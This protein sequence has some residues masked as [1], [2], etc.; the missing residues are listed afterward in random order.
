MKSCFLMG[1]SM[2]SLSAKWAE[3]LVSQPES[4]MGYQ[5][6][7]IRTKD[8]REFSEVVII[9][10]VI[11]SVMGVGTIPFKEDDIESITV[12]GKG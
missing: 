5:I 6:A 8:G 12:T 10:G 9:G 3:V 1:S 4:G 7:K 11:S 2:L